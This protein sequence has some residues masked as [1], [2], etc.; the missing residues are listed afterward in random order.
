[1]RDKTNDWAI[2][3]A[4]FDQRHIRLECPKE[5]QYKC[6]PCKQGDDGGQVF[7]IF[8]D[9]F[10]NEFS[11]DEFM[12]IFNEAGILITY[13]KKTDVAQGRSIFHGDTH[14]L[15]KSR[16]CINANSNGVFGFLLT[17]ET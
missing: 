1:M 16:S 5:V 11:I 3:F 4:F 7:F 10:Q 12:K 6:E 9:Q 15:I 17:I 13:D 2:G 8:Q 14:R